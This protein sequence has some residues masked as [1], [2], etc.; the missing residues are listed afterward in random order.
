MVLPIDPGLLVGSNRRSRPV[1]QIDAEQLL[2]QIA[3]E[4]L[5]A[6]ITRAV[7]ESL[8]SENGARLQVLSAAD[9]N[10]GDRLDSLRRQENTL[11]QESI[12]SELLDVVTGAQAIMEN[13]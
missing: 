5:F 4:Y 3:G 12:T 8:A 11:R 2:R 7:M 13:P 9:G 6:G 10:I 1:H